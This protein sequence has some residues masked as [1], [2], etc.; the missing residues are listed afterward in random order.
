MD[1]PLVGA[2]SEVEL[3]VSK[4]FD[5]GPVDKYVNVRKQH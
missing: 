1:Y 2:A 4:A 3:W 5:I